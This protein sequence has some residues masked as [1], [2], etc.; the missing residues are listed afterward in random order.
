MGIVSRNK[1]ATKAWVANYAARQ[2][3]GLSNSARRYYGFAPRAKSQ[4][5]GMSTWM[6]HTK[7]GRAKRAA[8]GYQ[9][10]RGINSALADLKTAFTKVKAIGKAFK[11]GGRV[12]KQAGGWFG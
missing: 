12:V 7:V 9:G 4:T 10:G 2:A 8:R 3:G 1:R 6:K 5:G 11:H